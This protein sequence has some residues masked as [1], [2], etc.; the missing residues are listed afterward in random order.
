MGKITFS[1]FCKAFTAHSEKPLSRIS[2][3]LLKLITGCESVKN[4]KGNCYSF[5]SK[6]LLEFLNG[7]ASLYE[8]IT[9]AVKNE[10]VIN[11]IRLDFE[12]ACNELLEEE[13]LDL[14]YADLVNQVEADESLSPE[15]KNYLLGGKG[16][17]YSNGWRIFVYAVGN[18]NLTNPKKKKRKKELNPSEIQRRI[19]ELI[20]KYPKPL[21]I[22]VPKE[23]TPEEMTYV[24][25]IL[26][27]FAEDAGVDVILEE[28][29]LSK[30][31]YKKYKAKLDRYRS[32]F[33]KA[34]SIRESLKDTKLES[35]VG[36]FKELE[37]DTYDGIIEKLEDY[38]P[39]SFVRMTSV[40]NYATT[41][42]LRSLIASSWVGSA[43][44]K[45]IC[46]ILVNEGRIQWK[47]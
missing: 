21:Q 11:H 19:I 9:E 40:L 30:G 43:E 26:E 22:K 7:E 16:D 23:I 20:S 1:S 33:Y 36:V 37:D 34:E 39:T 35:E 42:P 32:D 17:L 47:K 3:R 18:N 8:K 29:L 12:D 2:R 38:Y 4:T 25:A 5:K 28:E 10:A 45:G 15:N 13:A 24:S 44:K 6:E 14:V 31:D 41:I 46:H 27:A